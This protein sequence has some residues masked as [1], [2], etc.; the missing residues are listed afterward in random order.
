VA[1]TIGAPPDVDSDADTISWAG[2]TRAAGFDA[3]A[4][5]P[6][7]AN[8]AALLTDETGS[9][10]AVFANSP[11]LVTPALGTPSALVLTNATGLPVGSGISGLGTSVATALAVNVG[12]TGAFVV[13]GGALGTPASGTLTNCSG[14]PLG[15]LTGA[16]DLAAIEALSS[17]GIAVRSASNT[18]LQRSVAGTANEITATNGDGVSGNP[19]LSLPAALTFTG[20]TITGGTFSGPTL[21]GTVA[22]SITTSGSWDWTSGQYLRFGHANQAN[23]NDGKIGA[24]VL[25][26]GLNIIGV[27]TVAAAGRLITSLAN[28]HVW[29][30]GTNQQM[31]LDAGLTV[32]AAPTGGDKGAGT[33]NVQVDIYKN[34]TAYTNPDFVFEQ[35]YRGEIV[36]FAKNEGASEY[37]GLMPLDELRRF[38]KDRLHLPGVP[39]NA[40]AGIFARGDFVLRSLEEA[41]L[42]IM[43]LHEQLKVMADRVERLERPRGSDPHR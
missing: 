34:N 26:G 37:T 11:T 16:D 33:I 5:T 25:V 30:D 42:Y 22:G 28:H 9:G 40:G 18:W 6:S 29:Q 8:L 19:T 27:Q 32:G 39:R 41:H 36:E 3:F 35:F 24:A 7:S 15:G 43:D 31:S 10:S 12:T 1:I 4:A 20:K 2:V 38:T 21:S 17:T 14:L 13:N 23:A